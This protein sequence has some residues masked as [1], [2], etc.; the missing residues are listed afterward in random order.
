MSATA[1]A[2]EGRT[3]RAARPRPALVLAGESTPVLT[4]FGDVWRSRELLAVLARKE[5][6][7]RYRRA[8]FGLLWAVGIPLLQAV[9]LA[10]VLKHFVRFKT[11][12]DYPVF[13]FS[14]VL[15]WSFFSQSLN[16]A[17]GAIVDNRDISTKIYFPRC[18][19]PAMSVLSGVY[20]LALTTLLLI[21]FEA[22]TGVV[23]GADTLLL[24]PALILAVLLT[25]SI[26]LVLAVLHVYFRDVRFLVQAALMGW[27]Y[28]TPVF[29][30][31]QAVGR[32]APWLRANPATGVVELFRA[33]TVGADAGW[34]G[35]V[36]WSVCWTA[37]FLVAAT[38]L[39][40]R[41]DRVVAD[42]L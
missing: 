29:Y 40:R 28:L 27:F 35:A 20:G 36:G 18:L 12:G 3:V 9:I 21:G 11:G 17:S 1:E 13:V 7:V 14:G 31:L 38:F 4:L 5:F 24:V 8:S 25:L 37:L 10:V 30:P 41:F 39:Y 42:L 26:G 16:A 19:F 15:A 34:V 6:Y 22:A 2:A 32:I 33:A 23:P